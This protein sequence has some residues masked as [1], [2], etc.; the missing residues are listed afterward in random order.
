MPDSVLQLQ[1]TWTCSKKLSTSGK[2]TGDD[3]IKGYRP[4]RSYL[5]AQEFITAISSERVPVIKGT[6]DD[7]DVKIMVD[8]GSSVSLVDKAYL[9][10]GCVILRYY[11]HPQNIDV[12]GKFLLTPT[13]MRVR[14]EGYGHYVHMQAMLWD[15]SHH[16]GVLKSILS[17]ILMLLCLENHLLR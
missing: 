4:S 5:E 12:Y 1:P 17:S 3:H 7:S 14:W 8:S 16:N 10:L 9:P 11:N 2:W 6:L 13:N 15:A